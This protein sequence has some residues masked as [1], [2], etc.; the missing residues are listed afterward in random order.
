MRDELQSA[1]SLVAGGRTLDA[2]FT[3]VLPWKEQAPMSTALMSYIGAT[4]KSKLI[5]FQKGLGATGDAVASMKKVLNKSQ[6][7][8]AVLWSQWL[9]KRAKR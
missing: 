2:L 1:A 3:S 8:L 7:E 9:A 6:G 4:D 5:Q